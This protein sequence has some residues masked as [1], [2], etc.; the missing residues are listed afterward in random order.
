MLGDPIDIDDEGR[1]R[2]GRRSGGAALGR[3]FLVGGGGGARE[4]AGGLAIVGGR[5]GEEIVDESAIQAPAEL[6]HQQPHLRSGLEKRS[7]QGIPDS[8]V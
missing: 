8:R 4:G 5:S 2:I 3:L 1:D 6:S 7:R